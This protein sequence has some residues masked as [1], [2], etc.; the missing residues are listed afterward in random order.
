MGVIVD[1]RAVTEAKPA[2]TSA[3]RSEQYR[4]KSTTGRRTGNSQKALTIASLLGHSGMAA[5]VK[6]TSSF[7]QAVFSV[8]GV[9]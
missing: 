9:L 3:T 2:S 7:C 6:S 5:V 8:S 1:T 4:L